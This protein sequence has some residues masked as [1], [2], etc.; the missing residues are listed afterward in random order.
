M[1]LTLKVLNMACSACDETIT[2]AI[3]TLDPIVAANSKIKQVTVTTQVSESTIKQAVTA[4]D[5]AVT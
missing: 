5:Y 1:T 2:Q 4:A 3:K